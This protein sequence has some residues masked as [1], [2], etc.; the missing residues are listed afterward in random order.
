[1]GYT[2]G[3]GSGSTLEVVGSSGTVYGQLYQYNEGN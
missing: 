1:M 2:E 3:F